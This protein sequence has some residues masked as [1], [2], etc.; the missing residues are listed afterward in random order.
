MSYKTD[1]L[2]KGTR[3]RDTL[4]KRKAGDGTVVNDPTTG[5]STRFTDVEWDSPDCMGSGVKGVR[6]HTLRPIHTYKRKS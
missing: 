3:V 5:G 2:P 4:Q 1:W 6:R